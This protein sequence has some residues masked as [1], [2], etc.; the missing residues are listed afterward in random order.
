MGVSTGPLWLTFRLVIVAHLARVVHSITYMHRSIE[1]KIRFM[2][3]RVNYIKY[4]CVNI[5][6]QPIYIRRTLCWAGEKVCNQN[7]LR[8]IYLYLLIILL[9]INWHQCSIY[10]TYHCVLDL[11]VKARRQG[12]ITQGHV[13]EYMIIDACAHWD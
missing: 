1:L 10:K 3:R 9:G 7:V 12:H 11:Y 4:I 5:H 8:Y 13:D 2:H 6:K